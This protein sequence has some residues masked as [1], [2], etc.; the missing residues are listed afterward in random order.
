MISS[1][2]LTTIN[3]LKYYIMRFEKKMTVSIYGWDLT[4][5]RLQQ[6]HYMDTV[7]FLPL[8]PQEFQVYTYLIDLRRLKGW[9][10]LGVSSHLLHCNF[11]QQEPAL[12]LT[13]GKFC[14]VTLAYWMQFI[15]SKQW[16]N[17]NSPAN[18]KSK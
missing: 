10:D 8:S 6:R 16:R 15:T 9:V 18:S 7:Y 4:V 12:F 1:S 17:V 11:K 3:S 2:H 5:S 13:T 14:L